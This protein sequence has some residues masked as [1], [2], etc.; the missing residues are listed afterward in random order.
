MV[1]RFWKLT[2]GQVVDLSVGLKRQVYFVA[3]ASDLHCHAPSSDPNDPVDSLLIAGNPRLPSL[4]HPV[5][6]L[7]DLIERE[8]LL[9]NALVCPGDITNAVCS[10]GLQ[11]GWAALAELQRKLDCTHLFAT[12]GNHDVDSCGKHSPNAFAFT[13]NSRPDLPCSG[14]KRTKYFEEGFWLEDA[15]KETTFLMV[16]SAIDHHDMD[17]AKRGTFNQDRIDNIQ[18]A[19]N[20][21]DWPT[22]RRIA[23]LHHHP[24]LHSLPGNTS[25]DVLPT[26]DALLQMLIKEGFHLIIHGHRHHPRIVT[27]KNGHAVVAAGSFSA[28]LRKMGTYTRNMFHI[29][30]I[31]ACGNQQK[32]VVRSWEFGYGHG[33]RKATEQSAS[34]PHVAGYGVS[35]PSSLSIELAAS[36]PKHGELGQTQ[37]L[38]KYPDLRYLSP[39]DLETLIKELKINH[40]V[41]LNMDQYGEFQGLARIVEVPHNER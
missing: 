26:G 15:D 19:L 31:D 39:D 20:Q 1:F 6:S 18:K 28:M 14:E 9:A 37:L 32:G 34:I 5:Q 3:V 10:V 38:L 17:S 24:M 13:K 21:D 30:E 2:E 11:A 33:W 12:I 40:K 36:A 8:H 27:I 7:I 22:Y 35:L 4:Q 29:I 16:N 41:K 23:V 25:N